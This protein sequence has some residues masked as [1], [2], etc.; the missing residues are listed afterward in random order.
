MWVKLIALKGYNLAIALFQ[1]VI[2]RTHSCEISIGLKDA[3]A[4]QEKRKS[5]WV[6]CKSVPPPAVSVPKSRGETRESWRGS[7]F[8]EV[9]GRKDK[10][11]WYMVS[12]LRN[13][14]LTLDLDLDLD[15]SHSWSDKVFRL[16]I[17]WLMLTLCYYLQ[18]SMV[19][20]RDAQHVWDRDGVG[21]RERES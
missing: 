13:L 16:I 21:R 2:R 14:S 18:M 17:M 3:I 9:E 8:Q 7:V 5:Y 12:L 10:P 4:S 6:C 11:M 1:T 19:G 20:M 15:L